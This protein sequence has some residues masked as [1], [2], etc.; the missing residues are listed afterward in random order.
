M[1]TPRKTLYLIDG[2]GLAYRTYFALTGAGQDASRWTTKSGEPTAGTYGFAVKLFD[3]LDEKPDFFAVSFDVGRTFRDDL[4]AEYKGTREKMPDDLAVQIERIQELVKAFGIPILT[5][6]GYEADDVLGTAARRAVA[7]GARVVIITGDRDLLQLAD[8][9]VTIRLAG[10]KLKESVDYGPEQVKARFGLTPSAYIDY[11]ALVGDTSD[12]IPGVAGVGEKTATQLLQEYGSLDGIYQNL[13]KVANRFKTKLEAGKESAYLSKTLATIV[14]DVDF[15]FD[16][17]ACQV[18]PLDRDRLFEMFRVLEFSSL[19]RRLPEKSEETIG[20]GRR[21]G[22]RTDG[23]TDGHADGQT[24]GPVGG[25]TRGQANETGLRA[26]PRVAGPSGQMGMLAEPVAAP[27]GGLTETIVVDDLA[28]LQA[29]Q[30]DLRGAE[31]IAFDCETDRLSPVHSGLVGV[32]LAVREGQGYYIPVGHREGQQLA[33][34]VVREALRGP[35]T[36]PQIGK[37]AHNANYDYMTLIRHGL[38]ITPVTFDTLLGEWLTDPGSHALG[39]KKL[40]LVRLGVEMT[41]ISDL[42]GSGKKQITMDQV[43]I[44]AAAPYA[45]ADADVTLRLVPILQAELEAKDQLGL[46]YDLEMPL[47][48]V[49][50]EMELR[51]ITVDVP[52]LQTLSAELET[53]LSRVEAEIYE[54]VGYTFNINST[55]QLSEALFGKLGLRPPDKSR[56]TAAGKFSTAS[57]VLEELRDQHP[58]I[59]KIFEQR[60][61][62]KLKSTYVDALPQDVNPATGRVHTSFN[63]AGAITGRLSS[64]DPNLQNIPIRTELGRRVRRA[65]VAGEGLTLIS[66]DYSQI[67]LRIAAHYSGDEVLRDAFLQ[68]QDIHATTAAAVLGIAPGAVTKEQRR[69][70]KTINFGLLYGM[71]SFALSKQT[72]LTLG[73][74]EDF[75][76]S[77]FARFPKIKGYLDATKAMAADKGYVETLMGRRR[78]FPGLQANAGGRE[79]AI[80]KARAERE[81]INAPIQGTAADIMK[82]A[83]LEIGP[84]LKT[85]KLNARLLLQVHDELVL[86]CP[87]KEVAKTAQVLHQVME[88]T[89]TLDVPLGVEVRSGPNWEDLVAVK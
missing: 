88:S 44:A 13:G 30:A 32:S 21:T 19:L 55:Q 81:A 3:Y 48:P 73:E 71:G 46:L 57:D 38:T 53:Q 56:K 9:H 82:K 11:K 17:S 33:W 72:G 58:V 25:R 61:V 60:E 45:A 15:P 41:E 31:M 68:G 89:L 35:L 12:N 79:G 14:T 54:L 85:A 70:A 4:F 7:A 78:Y 69:N 28:K 2:H 39:L 77:Y 63:Q 80:A 65:F 26:A 16:L 66:A 8:E 5:A 40:A 87:P 20:G 52:Y 76:K 22:G 51:G 47:V 50:A 75:V 42:I 49:L 86:E 18:G 83:M 27:T 84:A 24:V 34:E 67:E 10:Q 6:E 37:V 62:S 1:P 59:T 74:A 23:Q 43:P 29:L 36:D 64:S